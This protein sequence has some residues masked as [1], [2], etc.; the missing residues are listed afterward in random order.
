MEEV[1]TEQ[2]VPAS[3]AIGGAVGGRCRGVDNI[4]ITSRG[5]GGGPGGEARR[6]VMGD[7][8]LECYESLG[9][10]L[11]YGHVRGGGGRGS[12]SGRDSHR[13]SQN[14]RRHCGMYDENKD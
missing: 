7:G 11:H 14:L 10:G 6:G 3:S 9:L 2:A 12:G 13:Q 1:I 8:I 5:G 4:T